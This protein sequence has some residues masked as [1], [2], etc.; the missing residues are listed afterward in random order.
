MMDD[1]PYTRIEAP[2]YK[3]KFHKS[4]FFFNDLIVNLPLVS[5]T[6]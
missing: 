1:K 2:F 6:Q 3:K 5:L 4:K